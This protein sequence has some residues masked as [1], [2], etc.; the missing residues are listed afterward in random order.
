M[1]HRKQ[2]AR[3][4]MSVSTAQHVDKTTSLTQAFQ[5]F[6]A[7]SE[8]LSSAYAQLE[9]K[10]AE[11]T[12][13]LASSNTA[14]DTEQL[15]KKR[16]ADRLSALLEA[17]P[18]AV[19][20]VDGRD[21]IDRFNPAA[22]ALFEGLRWG[23]RW[24]EVL[25]ENL[26]SRLGSGDW[27][28]QNELRVSV[29]Q[30][31]LGDGGQILVMIDTTEQRD[32]EERLQRQSRLSDMGEMAAQLAHQIRTPL[33]TA[34][35][36]GGQLSRPDLS[37]A[38][39][40]Q[41]AGQLVEGLKHTEQLVSDMLA[42]SR[43]G[44]FTANAISLRDTVRQAVD[45]L[46]PRLQA[47]DADL[48]L[49]IDEVQDDTMLGNRDA[50]VGVLCNLIEN[51]LNHTGQG[52]RIGIS[53]CLSAAGARVVVEDDGPGIPPDMRQQIFDPFFTTRERG[54]GLGLAVA[55][56]VVLAHGG[57]INTCSSAF[58]GA[59]FELNL[60]LCSDNMH[61]PAQQGEAS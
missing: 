2:P 22:E 44:S 51:A 1:L 5:E 35:L 19:V 17:M 13:E 21:R 24:S 57:N 12:A 55:Q 28:L 33:A 20:L 15:Q 47:C 53:L 7:L 29:S 36:Y 50:L 46:G 60:P 8:H 56:S 23:R 34:L 38:Q 26:L 52:A 45:T 41:F 9:S 37:D 42:F 58:G 61:H 32:L 14:C 40:A 49:T 3:M 54:T 10:V 39:R 31:P 59:C 11:L 43:G 18:A 4:F 16:L 27:L 30:R 48:S 25:Q 6:N